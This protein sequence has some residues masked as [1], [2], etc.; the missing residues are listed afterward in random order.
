MGISLI[1]T[2]R[3]ERR[4]IERFL[5]SIAAQTVQ[6]DEVIIVDGCSTDGT[7]ERVQAYLELPIICIQTPCN[8]S[9]GRNKAIELATHQIIAVTD[10]GCL[11]DTCWLERITDFAEDTD[12]VAGNYKPVVNSLFDA[13]QYSLNGLFKST[14]DLRSFVISSRSLAFRK[15]VW[16]EVGGYPEW[17]DYSEDMYFHLRLKSRYNVRLAK[18]AYVSWEQRPTVRALFFQFYRYMRGDGKAR[19]HTKRHLLRF[20]TYLAAVGLLY[21]GFRHDSGWLL[22]LLGAGLAYLAVPCFNFVRLRR[23]PLTVKAL[24]LISVLVVVMDVAKMSGYLRGLWW[25]W[26]MAG[27]SGRSTSALLSPHHHSPTE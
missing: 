24:A 15:R 18:D 21:L 2:V 12:V 6:P 9:E 25:S 19:M 1:T 3:N 8:I 11:L 22:L 17:L 14:D 27:R 16:Q 10:A 5:D 4:S 7:Y 26:T 13:C 23:Y 20:C